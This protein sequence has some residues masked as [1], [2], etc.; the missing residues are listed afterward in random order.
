VNRSTPKPR[1]FLGKREFFIFFLILSA[2][3][4]AFR[5]HSDQVQVTISSLDLDDT[6]ESVASHLRANDYRNFN[7][8]EWEERWY[9]MDST[10]L[11]VTYD[12]SGSVYK[13]EGGVPQINGVEATQWSLEQF[14]SALGPASF[15]GSSSAVGEPGRGHLS[16]P[17]HRLLIYIEPTGNRF[18]LF[19]SGR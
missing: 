19:E 15:V 4:I 17:Q 14:E 3:A 12:Q 13:I 7:P 6:K 18:L 5:F 1:V 8:S 11:N 9:R 2:I 10:G 16:Y